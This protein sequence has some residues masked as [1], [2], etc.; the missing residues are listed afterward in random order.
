MVLVIGAG[1]CIGRVFCAELRR[2]GH[3]YLLLRDRDYFE[4]HL[5]FDC[6]RKSKPDFLIN[7]SSYIGANTDDSEPAREEMLRTNTILPRLISQVCLMTNTPW[8]HV[9]SGGI[10]SGA[11]I[12]VAT[13]VVVE[14]KLPRV[15]LLKIAAQSPQK[16]RGFTESDE[17]NFSFRAAPCDFS[18]GTAALAEEAIRGI[19]RNFIWR[20]G[21]PFNERDEPENLLRHL[22]TREKI[23]DGVHPG[24]HTDDFARACL[25]LWERNAP[26]GI[27]NVT[28]PGIVTTRQI[29]EMIQKILK[30]LRFFDFWRDDSESH[31]QGNRGPRANC[32]LDVSKLLAT[33]VSMRP[34][35]EAVEDA[36]KN[37]RG[38]NSHDELNRAAA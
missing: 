7:A 34:L 10:Y 35:S 6:I 32:I 33:G 19:G 4:F 18:S 27:Y 16:L 29:V 20:M 17:P 21:V 31:N 23:H 11:K 12:V 2:R 28:N 13:G 22:Q 24:S 25:D 15:E 26:F 8:G 3:D 37:W 9:S 30:P 1:T 5:L 38:E 36:L 14:K